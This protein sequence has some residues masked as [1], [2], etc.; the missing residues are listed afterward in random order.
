MNMFWLPLILVALIA[1]GCA[2][3]SRKETAS[4]A[5]RQP[6]PRQREPIEPRERQRPSVPVPAP[7]PRTDPDRRESGQAKAPPA[8]SDEQDAAGEARGP[9]ESAEK[10][11]APEP[12]PAPSDR[13]TASAQ[14][15]ATDDLNT[16]ARIR[17]ALM[18][19][20]QLSFRSKNVIIVTSGEQVVLQGSVANH[21]EAERIRTIA[22]R[23]T[24][25]SIEDRL[26]VPQE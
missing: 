24:T 9:D 11:P 21:S 3:E 10:R 26:V 17:Q 14:S 7:K 19:D 2:G 12:A 4:V 15:Q 5:D 13:V 25:K 18:G 22:G 8:Q 16:T 20:D 1:T 23:L 6:A